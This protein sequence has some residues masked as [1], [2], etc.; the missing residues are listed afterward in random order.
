MPA[1]AAPPRLG[2][3]LRH[4]LLIAGF[5]GSLVLAAPAAAAVEYGVELGAIRIMPQSRS[6]PLRTELHP[7]LLGSAVGL[8]SFD[9]PGTSFSPGDATTPVFTFVQTFGGHFLVKVEGGIPPSFRLHGRGAVRAPGPSGT[10]FNVDLGSPTNQ[11]IATARQ[12]SPV[13]LLQYRPRDP[14]RRIQPYIGM[15]IGYTFFTGVRLGDAVAADLNRQFGMP[16]AALA[17]KPGPTTTTAHASPSWALAFNGGSSWLIGEHWALT[18]SISY[19]LLSTNARI[20]LQAADGTVLARSRTN[21]VL[22]PLIAG[23]LL[24]YRF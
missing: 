2:R 12:W 14:S 8:S 20:D 10:L 23:L 7:S 19:G 11:P 5:G 1:P 22:N 3:F 17:L 9:S 4:R 6:T 15:G 13:T 24:N 21:L 16:L 18:G